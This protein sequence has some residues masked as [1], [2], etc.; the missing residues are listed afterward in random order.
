[1]VDI[2]SWE[3][4]TARGLTGD[5]DLLPARRIDPAFDIR[6]FSLIQKLASQLHVRAFEAVVQERGPWVGWTVYKEA[7][8][9]P[10][11]NFQNK[12]VSMS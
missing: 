3:N 12:F 6:R 10:C 4:P 9:P 1:M 2:T 11:I 8:S 5:V 7:V